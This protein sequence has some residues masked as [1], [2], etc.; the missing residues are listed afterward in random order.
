M[1]HFV[2]RDLSGWKIFCH[3]I[4]QTVRLSEKKKLLNIKC[5]LIFSTNVVWNNSHSKKWERD[6]QKRI[7]IFM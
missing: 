4:S 5:V 3:I 7:L 6:Y 2:I 1:G